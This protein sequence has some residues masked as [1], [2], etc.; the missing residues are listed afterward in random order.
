MPTNRIKG[1]ILNVKGV[2]GFKFVFIKDSLMVME[3]PDD[4]HWALSMYGIKGD[5]VTEGRSFAAKGRG[6]MEF[7]KIMC[8]VRNDTL[9]VLNS[10]G[11]GSFADMVMIPISSWRDMIDISTWRKVDMSWINPLFSGSHINGSIVTMALNGEYCMLGGRYNSHEIMTSF[12]IKTRHKQSIEPWFEDGVAAPD[13]IKQ[14]V[15]IGNSRIFRHDN[16]ILYACGEGRYVSILVMEGNVVRQSI[17][18]YSIYPEYSSGDLSSG[19]FSPEYTPDGYRGV[20][21]YAT[22]NRIYIRQVMMYSD[23]TRFYPDDYKGY[24]YY[25]Y[26]EVEIY[27]WDGNF[28]ACYQTD[29]PF[30][31][32][33][34]T[35]DDR[36]MYVLTVSPRTQEYEMV[37]Y[38]LPEDC[39]VNE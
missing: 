31:D 37:R 9:D 12:N 23:G 4:R 2:L 13:M 18:I 36:T 32:M 27:D 8:C 16:R 33:Y 14:L 5:T 39:N 22:E 29:I 24:P 30:Y 15:Y 28:I 3:A 17:P 34:V 21:A 6:A 7:D 20:R 26:D 38:E 1:T 25:C 19:I 10:Y 35:E 11:G